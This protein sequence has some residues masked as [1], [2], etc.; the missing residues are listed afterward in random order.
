MQTHITILLSNELF[1]GEYLALMHIDLVTYYLAVADFDININIGMMNGL[2]LLIKADT[3]NMV[4][5]LGD[6]IIYLKL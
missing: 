6:N 4:R 3:S 2:F 5:N 1:V